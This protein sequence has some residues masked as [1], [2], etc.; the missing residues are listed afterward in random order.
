MEEQDDPARN[1]FRIDY[2]FPLADIREEGRKGRVVGLGRNTDD[3]TKRY[4]TPPEPLYRLDT[5]S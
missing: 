2:I 4:A 5:Q 3:P 1:G